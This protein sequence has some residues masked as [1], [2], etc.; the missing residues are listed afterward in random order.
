MP[1][2]VR[3][4][5]SYSVALLSQLSAR[6]VRAFWAAAVMAVLCWCADLVSPSLS[7]RLLAWSCSG[8]AVFAGLQVGV[9]VA[10]KARIQAGRA[11]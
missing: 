7:L 1:R 2:Y 9:L 11:D 10:L 4:R 8:F 5:E 3:N 6:V